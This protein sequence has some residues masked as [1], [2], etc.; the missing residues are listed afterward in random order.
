M[1]DGADQRKRWVT[2]MLAA[3]M[4]ARVATA[5]GARARVMPVKGVLVARRFYDDPAERPMSDCD[6][7]L[8][9]MGARDAARR[10]VAEGWRVADW[11]N[12][13]DVVDVAH[14]SIPG[15]HAD[16]HSRP[17]PV[18]YGAVTAAW[19][20][21]GATE[22]R[23]LFGVPVLVPDDRKLLV[24]LLGNILRDHIVNARAHTADDVARVLARSPRDVTSFAEVARDARL[25]LGCWAALDWVAARVSEP[26][27]G[28]LRDALALSSAERRL[29][30][31]RTGVLN[32]PSTP[33]LVARIV[34]RCVSDAPGDAA[35]GVGSAVY[36]VASARAL[37]AL[38]GLRERL[39]S[40]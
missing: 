12:D 31:L 35:V 5:L 28:A 18:G 2:Q 6:L 8:V 27:V 4:V 37:S 39:R 7:V 29:A 11:S 22:D 1:S 20:A 24:H 14:P 15:I 16:L 30:S 34:A 36:G 32:N 33:R 21:E 26:R 9:G 25:R 19:M 40:R 3:R 17:L 23:R 38:D 13:P 10:L